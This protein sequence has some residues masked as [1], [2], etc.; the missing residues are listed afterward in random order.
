MKSKI[1]EKELETIQSPDIQRFAEVAIENLPDYFFEVPASSTGKY[2]PAYALGEG[3]L[4]RHT[5]AAVRFANHLFGME[6]IREQFSDRERD[7]MIAALLLH[8]GWKHGTDG[9]TYTVF[10]HPVICA[11]W[12]RECEALNG[13]IPDKDREVIAC[14]IASHMGEWNTN[15]RSDVVLPKPQTPIQKFVHT[16]DYLASRK[17]IEVL[18]ECVPYLEGR[19]SYDEK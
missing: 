8:D 11:S 4:V 13:I 19:P 9:S 15:N 17:D 16:C 14:A 7:L 10:E 5:C 12:V 18:F 2:H 1:F 6:H 3:G